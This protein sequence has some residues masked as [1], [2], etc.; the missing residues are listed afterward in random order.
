L[1]AA[2]KREKVPAMSRVAVYP[3]TFDPITNGHLD[4]ADRGRRHF[5]HLSIAVLANEDKAP[6]FSVDERV[7]LIR[8]AVR[9]WDNV[10]VDTFDGLLVEYARRKRAHVI[11]RGIRAITD[12]EYEMQMAMMNRH[13]APD[14]ETVFLVPS[15]DYS[16]VSSRLV[17]E[18]AR[19]GGSVAGLVPENVSEALARRYESP[20]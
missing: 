15:E 7:G 19:L 11:V 13:L 6:L 10:D 16:Y 9:G 18:V 1:P 8:E 14:I 3:G 2:A 5:D 12:L 17:R 20:P 4:L